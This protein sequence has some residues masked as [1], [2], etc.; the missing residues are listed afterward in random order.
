MHWIRSGAFTI[1]V[2][3]A[4]AMATATT[5]IADRA[6]TPPPLSTPGDTSR[7]DLVASTTEDGWRYD[8]YR[9]EAYPCSISGYQ[10]FTIAT[11]TGADPHREIPLWTFMHGGGT[12]YFRPDGTPTSTQHM[13]EEPLSRQQGSLRTGALNARIA[14]S[15]AEIRLM[16]V[17]MCNRDI[18]GG[19]GLDDPNNPNT[20]PDGRPRYT[21]GLL[22]TKAAVQ[23]ATTT[24]PTDDHFLYGGSA[25]SYG[26]FHVAYGLQQQGLAPAGVVA[27]SG[28]MNTLWQEANRDSPVCGHSD[29]WASIFP[30]RLHPAIT[31]GTNDPDQIVTSGRL[32]VPM[33]D[34]WTIGDPGQCGTTPMTCPSRT[35]ATTR[36]GSVDCMHEPL[37]RALEP[38][39]RSHSM[40]LCVTATGSNRQCDL[41][42]PTTDQGAVNTLPGEPADFN[43]KIL[44][45][46][47]ERT[48]DDQD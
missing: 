14:A 4:I 12:G 17:S 37:R 11:R 45:W 42:T 3:G 29:E 21:N 44:A 46:V 30:R 16:A 41:H 38:D 31:T 15:T 1:A 5:G 32:T 19:F 6:P 8:Q 18:Y 33:F 23:F 7:I 20:T 35:G 24:Y 10:T 34:V 28:V 48:Q 43:A 47:H 26:T 39:P 25:G 9:N 2:T 13:T 22:A 40:R 27:D 36:L